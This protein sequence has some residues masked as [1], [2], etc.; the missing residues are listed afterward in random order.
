MRLLHLTFAGHDRAPAQVVFDPRLT[1]IYGASDT[2]KS[3]VTE[4]IDYMLGARKL[5]MIPEADGYTQILLGVEF[6]DGSVVTLMRGPHSGKV[7]VYPS[8]TGRR[9]GGSRSATSAATSIRASPT[10]ATAPA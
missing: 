7:S 3:F 8:S 4:S 1:V 6:P 10:W 9:T 2:G 5:G